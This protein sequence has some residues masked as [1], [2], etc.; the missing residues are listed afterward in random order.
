MESRDY[1]K[2]TLDLLK[3]TEKSTSEIASL[4]SRDFY[5]TT[6]LLEEM[7]KENLLIKIEIKNFTYWKLKNGK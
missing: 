3:G 6:R 5:F 1:K 7:E 2:T 4:L